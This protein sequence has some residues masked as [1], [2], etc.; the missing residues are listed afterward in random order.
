VTDADLVLGYLDP[1]SF[2]GGRMPLDVDRARKAL[3][4][5]GDPLGLEPEEAAAGI[6]R[7]V[8]AHH[9]DVDIAATDSLRGE[10]AAA[11]RPPSPQLLV[12]AD[13]EPLHAVADVVEAVADSEAGAVLRCTLCRTRLG[14]YTDSYAAGAHVRELGW[15]AAGPYGGGLRPDYVLRELS[16]PGCGTALSYEV[17]HRD[18]PV[19]TGSRLV[20]KRP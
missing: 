2:L 12:A 17:Q 6:F 4:T 1:A 19:P 18:D 9:G 15:E 5:I 20:V 8:N 13:G 16:C 3:A 7:I 11:R 10:R 14:A